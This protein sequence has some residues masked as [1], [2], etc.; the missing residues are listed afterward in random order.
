[1]E[2]A[3]PAKPVTTALRLPITT[4][5]PG[6]LPEA[7]TDR[8][9]AVTVTPPGSPLPVAAP[10]PPPQPANNA[11]ALIV[12]VPESANDDP[13]RKLMLIAP[14]NPTIEWGHYND[15]RCD[16]RNLICAG[17]WHSEIAVS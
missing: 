7:L 15:A 16:C 2:Y 5:V 4:G 11:S 10:P 17:S 12:K 6:P 13:Q 3:A 9:P 1:M 14:T 8:N